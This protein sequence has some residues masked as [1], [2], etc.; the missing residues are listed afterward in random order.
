MNNQRLQ[1][2]FLFALLTGVFVLLFF[3]FRPFL[4]PLL[5]AIVFAV[6]FQP[7]YEK[8][9]SYLGNKQS[10]TAFFTAIIII[11]CIFIP[12]S[13]LGKQIFNE[14]KELYISIVE[15][16][17]KVSY[18]NAVNIFAETIEDF[19]PGV[20]N[21]SDDIS[22]TIDSYLKD[23]LEW[24]TSSIGSAFGSI[25]VLLIDLFVFFIALYYFL[26]DGRQFKR[27]LI[28]LSPFTDTDDE[29]VFKK[30]QLA[31]NSVI[32]GNLTIAVLQG[33]L[34]A[35]GFAIFGVPNSVLWGTVAAMAALIPGIGT[36]LVIFPGVLFLFITDNTFAGL[37]LIVWGVLAVGAVDNLLGPKLI[38][39]GLHLHPL[40]VLLAVLGGI[41]FFGPIGILM[42]PLTL[43]LLFAFLSIYSNRG[44][45]L[46]ETK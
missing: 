7:F 38:G 36:A 41:S 23:G 13:I 31:V 20:N 22:N 4:S 44:N 10:L 5:L 2:Y 43:S 3:V 28:E 42:G 40:L 6:V 35:I 16:N 11:A 37:G 46:Q 1:P 29:G 21:L 26:R 45:N 25:T 33:F 32:K 19:V 8:L 30:L 9:L 12:V 34:T 17:S 14:A 39:R 27:A 15:G 18:D 24:I